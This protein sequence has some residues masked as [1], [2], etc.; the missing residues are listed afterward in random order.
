MRVWTVTSD[1][2]WSEFALEADSFWFNGRVIISHVPET[3]E[4]D[5]TVLVPNQTRWINDVDEFH[6]GPQ[7]TLRDALKVFFAREREIAREERA[8][9]ALM[10]RYQVDWSE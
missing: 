3:G 5:T 7:P 8:L 2:E 1:P 6:L 10:E 9:T 4:W